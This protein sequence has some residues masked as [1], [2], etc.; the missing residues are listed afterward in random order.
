M[1]KVRTLL[2]LFVVVTLVAVLTVVV[3]SAYFTDEETSQNNFIETGTIDIAVDGEN[4]W[5]SDAEYNLED[6][7]PG[8]TDYTEFTIQNVGTN[9]ANVWKA[10]TFTAWE[11][12]P[13]SEPECVAEGGTW[14]PDPAITPYL[15]SCSGNTPVTDLENEIR[16]DLSVIV[17]DAGGAAVWNQTVYAIDDDLTLAQVYGTNGNQVYLG[18]IPAG[19]SMKVTQ[20]YHM[21]EDADNRYQG[22]TMTY[23]INLTA[24]QLKGTV[25]LENKQPNLP[26]T[27]AWWVQHDGISG[28][29]TYNVKDS[30]FDFSFT[31]VAP[32]SSTTY[33]LIAYND[34]W[35][36]PATTLGSATSDGSGNI[37][38]SGTLDLGFDLTN[39]KVWLVTDADYNQASST[40]A[41]WNPA[42]YLF[43]AGLMD[44]YDSL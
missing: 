6:L 24:E 8:Q 36:T 13:I 3:T 4:A 18:M 9:P 39:Q 32:L 12:A 15:G 29:M 16:Y 21:D 17:Y 25:Y 40:M 26:T 30:T 33:Y 1:K 5:S 43:E 10:L 14:T 42:N 37:T 27:D 23:N 28:E 2:S 35:G 34:P 44:Y 20:S 19:Y 41:G 22:D 11:N 31:G 7:K 38:I